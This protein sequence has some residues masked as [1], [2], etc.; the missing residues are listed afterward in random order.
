MR[1]QLQCYS[2][3]FAETQNVISVNRALLRPHPEQL[4]ASYKSETMLLVGHLC[5]LVV[6]TKYS[7]ERPPLKRSGGLFCISEPIMVSDSVINLY[8]LIVNI[9]TLFFISLLALLVEWRRNVSIT[10]NYS[11]Y[12]YWLNEVLLFKK[13]TLDWTRFQLFHNAKFNYVT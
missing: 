2:G 4:D 8:I 5:Y 10:R 13:E 3:T 11:N 12:A 9:H 7:K 1:R 6:H